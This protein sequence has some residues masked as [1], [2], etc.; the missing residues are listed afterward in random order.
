MDSC[1]MFLCTSRGSDCI[2]DFI[3]QLI[4]S[5]YFNPILMSF[6]AE[7]L[8]RIYVPK[9]VHLHGVPISIIQDNG[10]IFTSSF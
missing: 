9:I 10:S 7:M 2:L 4:K 8:A 6:S 5:V 3:D 1:S